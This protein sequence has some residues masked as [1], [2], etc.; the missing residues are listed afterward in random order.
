VA[1]AY[2]MMTDLPEGERGGMARAV[3]AAI[4]EWRLGSYDVMIEHLYHLREAHEGG[5]GRMPFEYARLVGVWT[6]L[7]LC[8][9][10]AAYRLT[11][12]TFPFSPRFADAVGSR[13]LARFS[14]WWRQTEK[15][16]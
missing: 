15:P 16:D 8:G 13:I 9:R 3:E 5:I 10:G 6:L 1:A 7:K 12:G 11:P 2:S 14:G 4:E